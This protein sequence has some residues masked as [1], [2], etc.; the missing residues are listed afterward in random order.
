MRTFTTII[1]LSCLAL[2]AAC[3]GPGN[4]AT[5]PQALPAEATFVDIG[6]HIVHFN[7]G[8]TIDLTPE[9]AQTY[10]FVRSK[11]RAMLTVSVIEKSNNSPTPAEISVNVRNLTGQLKN[12][13]MRTI[14]EQGSIYYIGDTAVANR[15]T[16]TFVITVTPE[17][18]DQPT[19]V[20]FSREFYTN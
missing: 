5:V 10:D 20:Q 7:A 17:G 16:L 1:T 3:G 8:P 6:D 11:S 4:D 2:L 12:M 19:D 13:V 9:I 14:T 15:E 18:V